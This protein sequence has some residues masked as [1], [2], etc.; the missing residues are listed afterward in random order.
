LLLQ[1]EKREE[2]STRKEAD[3]DITFEK[4]KSKNQKEGEEMEMEMKKIMK[5]EGMMCGHCE[6]AVKKALEALPQVEEA[7]VSHEDNMAVVTL[8]ETVDDERLIKAVEDK[9]YKVLTVE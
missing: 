6:A 9:D 2:I 7:K 1:L 4:N 8:K 3:N 5:I